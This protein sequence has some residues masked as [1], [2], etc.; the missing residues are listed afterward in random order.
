MNSFAHYPCPLRSLNTLFCSPTQVGSHYEHWLAIAHHP[1]AKKSVPSTQSSKERPTSIDSALTGPMATLLTRYH[2]F[3]ARGAPILVLGRR[4][5]RKS[6][7][8]IVHGYID[9]RE[10]VRYEL[11]AN[12][13]ASSGGPVG[14]MAESG[15]T[16]CA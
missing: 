8:G 13:N 10:F 7:F 9:D 15:L 3:K 5:N 2:P 6:S 16:R 14:H 1:R 11:S 4:N 12:Q